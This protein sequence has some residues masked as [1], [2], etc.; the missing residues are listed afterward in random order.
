VRA[1]VIGVFVVAVLPSIALA[2]PGATPSPSSSADIER[3]QQEQQ[4]RMQESA[5]DRPAL[6]SPSDGAP[7]K[8][9]LSSLPIETPCFPVR[10]VKLQGAPGEADGT[11]PFAWLARQLKAVEGQCIGKTAIAA[12]QTAANTALIERGYITSRVLVPEQ[13]VA[14]GVLALTVVAGRVSG[15]RGSAIGWSRTVL[16]F[17]PGAVYNQRDVD[18]ALE[19]VRRLAGQGDTV[20]DIE[21]GEAPGESVIVVKRGQSGDASPRYAMKRWHATVGI[22]NYG[23]DS[24]GRYTLTG[25][26]SFDSPLNLFDQL[27]VSGSTNADWQSHDNAARSAAVNWNVPIG[28]ASFFVNASRSRYLQSVAGFL[29]PLRYSGDSAELSAGLAFVPYRSASART[30]A[31]IK[32]YRRYNHAYLNGESID[33]Q[34]RDLVGYEATLSQTQYVGPAAFSAGVGWRQTLAGA[35]RRPGTILGHGAWNGKTRVLTANAQAFLPFAVGPAALRYSTQFDIQRAMTRLVPSDY[36]TIGTPYT[37]RGFDGQTTLAAERGWAWRN[38]IGISI[39]GQIPFIALD[40]GQVSGP[41]ARYLAGT[42]LAGA[43]LG[44]RGRFNAASFAALDYEAT[45]G[46]PIAKPQALQTGYPSLLF[47]A[48]ARI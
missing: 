47:Q 31:Q 2:T 33:Y 38:E 20:L 32:L 30:V 42:L 44:V 46:W 9:D 6:L 8:I 29:E 10:T 3:R 18:Q 14:G 16:P 13:N 28:Y 26:F 23:L 19:S 48:T 15:V 34:Y 12:I 35:T 45:L 24:T 40:A 37:V 27:T 11:H 41:S 4:A 43:A 25:T 22:D 7:S 17:Y 21:P 39:R 1:V 36:F 5:A